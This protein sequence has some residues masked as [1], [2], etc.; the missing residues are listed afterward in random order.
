MI[1]K[2][3]SDCFCISLDHG[4]LRQALDADPVSGGLSALIEERCPHLFASL[5]VFVSRPHVD[6]MAKVVAAVEKVVALPAYREEVLARAPEIARLDPGA[7]GAFIGYDFHIAAE[8]PRLIEINTNAGGALLNGLLGRAQRAC[9]EE[10]AR[11]MGGPVP[12]GRLEQ[13]IFDMF[14]REWQLAGREGASSRIAIVDDSPE[15]QY[16]YPEFLL[17]ERLFR[18]LG[19]QADVLAPED[20]QYDGEL[21]DARGRIDLVYNRLTDFSLAEEAHAALRAAYLSGA[22]IVTPHPRAHA[23]YADKRNL[24]LLSDA[25][26]L[27]ALGAR[28]ETISVLMRG[29]PRTQLVSTADAEALWSARRRLFFKPATGYGSKAAYRGD[30]LTRRVWSE[31]LAG[32]YVAQELVEPGRRRVGPDAIL[33]ADVRNY[34]YDGK[35]QLLAARLYQGQTTNFRTA[36]GGFAPVLT[37]LATIC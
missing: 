11:L 27:A 25:S 1:D 3:N 13:T 9:C 23:L 19:V 5:P 36:G 18:R 26:R 21:R 37:A 8:G 33:K 22:A 7:R 35:V 16:L 6:E 34:V 4:A 30:K 14:V 15:E 31:I 12:A 10:V 32:E 29:V 2:L 20:L 17:F 24:A 28:D